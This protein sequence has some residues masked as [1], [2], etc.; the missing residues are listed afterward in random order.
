M[1]PVVP[2]A[3]RW[4]PK[5]FDDLRTWHWDIRGHH[6]SGLTALPGRW[7]HCKAAA[8]FGAFGP[9]AGAERIRC[10]LIA[11]FIG[12]LS[13]TAAF[14]R[15]FHGTTTRTVAFI[16]YSGGSSLLSWSPW[17]LSFSR[18]VRGDIAGPM[19][20]CPHL[21]LIIHFSCW[22]PL[23]GLTEQMSSV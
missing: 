16:L 11:A 23:L 15:S 18:K 19:G 4:I 7:S 6:S 3:E 13:K 2:M 14:A 10:W 8:R 12:C 21:F 20:T 1:L 17:Q 5:P 22:S 9:V